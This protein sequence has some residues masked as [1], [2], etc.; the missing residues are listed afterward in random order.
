[1]SCACCRTVVESAPT[2]M[3]SRGVGRFRLTGHAEILADAGPGM[4]RREGVLTAVGY[5]RGHAEYLRYDTA[6]SAAGP[7]RA[8]SSNAQP[9]IAPAT[10]SKS[11]AAEGDL[12][13]PTPSCAYALSSTTTTS[14]RIGRITSPRNTCAFTPM[15]IDSLPDQPLT[16]DEFIF[17]ACELAPVW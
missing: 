2:A 17:N 1:M 13:A 8:A 3:F 4:D 14:A 7:S 9:A 5:L 10:D 12:T 15:T 16:A 11:Q 6:L